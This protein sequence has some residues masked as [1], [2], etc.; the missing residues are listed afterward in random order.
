M[1]LFVEPNVSK[2]EKIIDNEFVDGMTLLHH[3]G[4]MFGIGC[5]ATDQIAIQKITKLKQRDSKAGFILLVPDIQW[6]EDN[7][8][9][10]PERQ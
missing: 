1:K 8:V 2:L 3:T 9:P 7:E 6:F 4:N 10:I 5:R